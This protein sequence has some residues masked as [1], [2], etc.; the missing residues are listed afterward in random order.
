MSKKCDKYESYFIFTKD[1]DFKSHLIECED[2]RKEY[3]TQEK[4]SSLIKEVKDVYKKKSTAKLRATIAACFVMLSII[5]GTIV[6]V[7]IDNYKLSQLKYSDHGYFYEIGMPTDDY[8]LI[9][10]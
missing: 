7:S 8:G 6:P 3:D 1:E 5:V 4:V 9:D 2:C 10:I